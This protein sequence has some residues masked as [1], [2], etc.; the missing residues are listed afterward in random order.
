MSRSITEAEQKK[1]PTDAAKSE[2]A[3]S[4]NRGG[5]LTEL[6]KLLLPDDAEFGL[7]VDAPKGGFVP[8]VLASIRGQGF[9]SEDFIKGRV[10]E[11]NSKLTQNFG[12]YRI[13]LKS[14]E[15]DGNWYVN[16]FVDGVSQPLFIRAAGMDGLALG[17]SRDRRRSG[18]CAPRYWRQLFTEDE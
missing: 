8:G 16:A 18:C 17:I 11:I 6:V 4:A 2:L 13:S 14:Y 12:D 15:R 10:S 3:I 9:R 5:A 1:A 7:V